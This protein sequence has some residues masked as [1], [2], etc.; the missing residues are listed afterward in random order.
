M[1]QALAAVQDL[2]PAP[3]TCCGGDTDCTWLSQAPPACAPPLHPY[4]G[5]VMGPQHLLSW[6]VGR[7]QR[8]PGQRAG[9]AAL[10]SM[11]GLLWLTFPSPSALCRSRAGVAC[12]YMWWG[13]L[14]VWTPS[15]FPQSALP[16]LSLI[17]SLGVSSP[18]TLGACLQQ[19]TGAAWSSGPTAAGRGRSGPRDA[20]PGEGPAGGKGER[21][22]AMWCH[23]TPRPDPAGQI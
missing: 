2:S 21:E 10:Q 18:C 14:R 9:Q 15:A 1:S 12:A 5:A 11:P 3:A 22:R 4:G 13:G 6:G 17:S 23:Q 7:I 8:P 20:D 16:P 19:Q